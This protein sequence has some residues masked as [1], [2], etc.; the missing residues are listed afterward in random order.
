MQGYATQN[1]DAPNPIFCGH[2]RD[3]IWLATGDL[4]YTDNDGYFYFVSR[5]GDLIKQDGYSIA[6]AEIESKIMELDLAIEA[7]CVVADVDADEI[8]IAHAFIKLSE[9]DSNTRHRV[10]RLIALLTKSTRPR[11]TTFVKEIPTTLNGKV[12][13]KGLLNSARG[14]VA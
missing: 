1:A 12:D 14:G 2:Y 8:E 10:R 7:V 13:R 5:Q 11:K 6:A 9:P 3:D 4:F